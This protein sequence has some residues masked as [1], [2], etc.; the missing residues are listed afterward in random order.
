MTTAP[1]FLS[2]VL[3]AGSGALWF[4]EVRN[5]SV[6]EDRRAFVA[7]W[8]VA[9][10]LGIEA[11]GS[12]VG[13]FG[14]ISAALGIFGSCFFLLTVLVSPQKVGSGAIAVGGTLPH[15]SAPDE[16]GQTFDSAVLRG[17]PVLIKFFRAHW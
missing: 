13:W 4:R 12:G 7:T 15:F 14:G 16:N 6:P 3:L 17:H 11:L 10:A 8:L 2:F 5:V 9:L 1:G